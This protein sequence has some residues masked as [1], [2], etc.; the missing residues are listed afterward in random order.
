[1]PK[2]S[3]FFCVIFLLR[4]LCQDIYFAICLM[5]LI[6]LLSIAILEQNKFK[7]FC[8]S[9]GSDIP[10]LISLVLLSFKFKDWICWKST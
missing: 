2:S 7:L 8:E 9:V 4:T 1:M 5:I 10:I 3:V 6:F